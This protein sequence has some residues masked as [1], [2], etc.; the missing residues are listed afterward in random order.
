MSIGLEAADDIIAD[1]AQALAALA[2]GR[3]PAGA[4]PAAA[5]EGSTTAA[6]SPFAA[7]RSPYSFPL[8]HRDGRGGK[9]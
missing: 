4:P 9:G 6:A 1:L 8:A 7:R 2:P 3:G 5:G